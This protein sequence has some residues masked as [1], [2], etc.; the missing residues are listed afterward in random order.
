MTS[1]GSSVEN[2]SPAFGRIII[3]S[4][5]EFLFFIST[6]VLGDENSSFSLSLDE[7]SNFK[8]WAEG[9]ELILGINYVFQFYNHTRVIDLLRSNIHVLRRSK[10]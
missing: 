6:C 3:L 1:F 7:K 4:F 5:P 2:R 10:F 8:V 9:P